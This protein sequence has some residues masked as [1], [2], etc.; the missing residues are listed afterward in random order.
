MHG[1]T[2]CRAFHD[3]RIGKRPRTRRQRVGDDA[4]ERDDRDVTR[5]KST[6]STTARDDATRTGIA[7]VLCV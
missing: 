6:R 5:D 7:H 3:R 2:K 1:N 4:I